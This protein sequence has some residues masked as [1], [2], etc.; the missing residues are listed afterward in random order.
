MPP[1]GFFSFLLFFLFLIVGPEQSG[2]KMPTLC[3]TIFITGSSSK[4]T[5]FED[6]HFCFRGMSGQDGSRFP[7]NSEILPFVPVQSDEDEQHG[8]EAPHGGAA[9]AEER[10][11]DADDRHESYGHA[12]VYEQVHEYAA[13]GAV[14]VDA[15]EGLAAAFGVVDDPP[16]QEYIQEYHQ[17]ASEEAPFLSDGAEDEVGA[18]FGDEAVGGLC[19]AQVAF[20]EEASGAYGD[21]GLVDIVTHSGRVF[22]HSEQH[23][24]TLSLVVLKHIIEKEIRGEYQQ[25]SGQEGHYRKVGEGVALSE[26]LE[27]HERKGQQHHSEKYPE[28]VYSGKPRHQGKEFRHKREQHKKW[29]AENQ[30]PFEPSGIQAYT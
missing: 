22:L 12:D 10:E 4:T 30:P 15:G 26:C 29:D 27:C 23:L 5:C 7:G 28:R 6:K 14:A 24:Y 2:T 20:A 25:Q 13:G 19:A 16:H 9:I 3:C 11:G 21:L 8:R 18:L 1:V 17:G